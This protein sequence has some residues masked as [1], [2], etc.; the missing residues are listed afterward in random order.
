MHHNLFT[1]NVRALAAAVVTAKGRVASEH[2]H[3][4]SRCKHCIKTLILVVAS[5]MMLL[6]AL[7]TTMTVDR[8]AAP[9]HVTSTS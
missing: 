3:I 9:K 4:G 5:M 2:C 6:V 7:L 1:S 8:G